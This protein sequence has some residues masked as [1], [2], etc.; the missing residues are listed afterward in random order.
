MSRSLVTLLALAWLAACGP[1]LTRTPA[2]WHEESLGYYVKP[3]EKGRLLD[4]PWR[5]ASH[6]PAGE[7][8]RTSLEDPN[9]AFT[10]ATDDGVL[11][12]ASQY[13]DP[14]D[15]RKPSDV[16]VDRWLEEMVVYPQKG[17][18]RLYSVLVPPIK[19][20][21]HV[22]H[23]MVPYSGGVIGPQRGTSTVYSGRSVE[24]VRREDFPFQGG[25]A[26]ELTAKLT[27]SGAP[28]AD[29]ALYLAILRP[30]IGDDMLV[31]GYSNSP[32][33]FD[34]GLSD[35]RGLAHRISYP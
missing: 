17:R 34:D 6:E 28:E 20:T 1:T 10:R 33:K 29:L 9:L 7:G 18:Y 16:L 4:S 5:I 27:P 35:A 21:A 2:G 13:V 26:T 19:T 32:R 22:R 15:A 12:V 30:T 23:S 11:V 31:V 24:I 8:Y 3:T 14:A 25:R